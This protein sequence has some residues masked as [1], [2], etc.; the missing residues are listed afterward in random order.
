MNL[1]IVRQPELAEERAGRARAST[2]FGSGK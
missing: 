1:R 2:S